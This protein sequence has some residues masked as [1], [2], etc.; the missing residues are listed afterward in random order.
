MKTIRLTHVNLRVS[1]VN[2][3]ARF[4]EAAL[5]LERIPRG[6]AEGVGAWFRLGTAELH[7]GEDPA[8]QPLSKRHF[9]VE[10]DDLDGARRDVLAAGGAIEKEDAGRRFWTRDP[11]GNRIEIVQAPPIPR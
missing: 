9:A 6:D 5:G 10:V 1:N 11:D 4:Y 3:A 7:L 8:P 2:A